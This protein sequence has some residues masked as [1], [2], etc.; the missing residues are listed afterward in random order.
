M[1]DSG[2][3]LMALVGSG[4]LLSG[5]LFAAFADLETIDLPIRRACYWVMVC[6]WVGGV[7][8]AGRLVFA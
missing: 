1:S 5:G 3:L 4:L 2:N 7:I 8:C 6:L